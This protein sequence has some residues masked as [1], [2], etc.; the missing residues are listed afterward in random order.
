M[1]VFTLSGL[2]PEENAFALARYSRSAKPMQDILSEVNAERTTNFMNKFVLNYGHA[3]VRDMAHVTACFEDISILAAIELED[4]Q[5]WDGQER[6]TRYQDFAGSGYYIPDFPEEKFIE[7]YITSIERLFGAYRVIFEKVFEEI[8][9]NTPRPPDM[10]ESKFNSAVRARSF[11]IVR[12]LLPYATLTS[13]GQIMNARNMEKQISRLLTSTNQEFQAIANNL[14]KAS[15]KEFSLT[16]TGPSS[17]I[18]LPNLLKHAGTSEYA[19]ITDEIVLEFLECYIRPALDV[20]PE[21]NEV[22]VTLAMDLT[23]ELEVLTNFIYRRSNYPYNTIAHVL[24]TR[25]PKS[26][27]AAVL[28]TLDKARGPFDVLPVEYQGGSPII[29]DVL[30]DGKSMQDLFRHRRMAQLRQSVT[31]CHGFEPF[32]KWVGLSGVS[33][34]VSKELISKVGPDYDLAMLGSLNAPGQYQT[35]LGYLRRAIFKMDYAQAAYLIETRSSSQGHFSYRRVVGEMYKLLE[36]YHPEFARSI[37]I[38]PFEKG[39]FLAR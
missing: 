38:T 8:V 19:R 2:T 7:E 34:I 27:H 5:L 4:E 1:R 21:G 16:P 26:K 39:E 15:S 11:D 25:V 18:M 33:E 31:N 22:S 14:I 29:F 24:A 20:L 10:S 32:F 9:T 35:P 12:G 36:T 13:V 3:S 30:L 37:R 6:S 17:E 28:E 23:Y